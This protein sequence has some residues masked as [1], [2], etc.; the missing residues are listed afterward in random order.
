MGL[1]IKN[2]NTFELTDDLASIFSLPIEETKED[3]QSLKEDI[4]SLKIDNEE[5]ANIK[6]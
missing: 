4:Y 1:T 3:Y 2:K 6:I 5:K